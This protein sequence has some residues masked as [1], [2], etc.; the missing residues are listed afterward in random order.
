MN[1]IIVGGGKTG[2]YVANLL[3]ANH[4]RVTVMAD[5]CVETRKDARYAT[6]D[7]V[8]ALL[9]RAEKSGFVHQI[10]N[11]DGEDKIVGICNCS[12]TTC[13]ALRTSQLFNTPNMSA[14]AYRAHVD[15]AGLDRL[16][17]SAAAGVAAEG[18]IYARDGN[19]HASGQDAG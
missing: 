6:Y 11:L 17:G 4:C 19:R 2:V 12:P 9:E 16:A 14:S 1:V 18:L 15:H 10:T 5:Y 3:R 8:M 13:N 7:E